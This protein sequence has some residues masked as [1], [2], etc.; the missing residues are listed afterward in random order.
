M[1]TLQEKFESLALRLKGLEPASHLAD[2]RKVLK[3]MNHQVRLLQNAGAGGREV[4]QAR[5]L[6][7]DVLIRTLWDQDRKSVV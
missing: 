5:A 3:L 7:V 2:Y 6:L 4:C 1:R